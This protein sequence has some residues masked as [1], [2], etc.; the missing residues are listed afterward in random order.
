[1][2]ANIINDIAE[3]NKAGVVKSISILSHHLLVGTK[4]YE[5]TGKTYTINA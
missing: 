3:N 2:Y 5:R 1:V 4:I